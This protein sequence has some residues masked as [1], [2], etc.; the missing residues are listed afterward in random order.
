MT[1]PHRT[2]AVLGSPIRHS[3]SPA[4]H[5]AAY[6]ELGLPWEYGS[7]E[8][9]EGKLGEFLAGLDATWRGLSLTMPLKRE[10]L[11]HVDDVDDTG[12]LVGASNTVLFEQ[13]RVLGFNTDVYGAKMAMIGAGLSQVKSALVL[14]T[15]ATASSVLAALAEL[16]C[17]NVSFMARSPARADALLALARRLKVTATLGGYD[18]MPRETDLVVSTLPGTTDLVRSFPEEF[19]Q[20]TPLVDIAYDPWPTELA[21][22]W[23]QAG[24]RAHSGLDMLIHQAIAQVRIFTGG[25]SDTVLPG[26]ESV[27][28]AM[29][30]AVTPA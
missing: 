4:L 30:A 13:G 23:L 9:S 16:G 26:E 10:V 28:R 20:D 24:G 1:E 14:G 7:V 15:G 2:L 6:R 17:T 27:L 11:D 29:R 3:Q 18:V 25:T 22:H 19:R 5:L 21:R 12:A 8:V